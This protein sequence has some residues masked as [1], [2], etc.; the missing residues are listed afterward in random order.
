MASKWLTD[1]APLE[2][3][4]KW[5]KLCTYIPHRV[6][7]DNFSKNAQNKDGLH[8]YCNDCRNV[9]RTRRKIHDKN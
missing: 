6:P 3:I 5:G 9:I 2:F 8:S 1:E 7:I 4:L